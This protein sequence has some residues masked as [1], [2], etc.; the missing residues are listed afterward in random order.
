[1]TIEFNDEPWKQRQP[2]HDDRKIGVK[3]L[4]SGG[5]MMIE[6]KKSTK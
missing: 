1:M 2:P 5:R 4:K 6:G 3:N